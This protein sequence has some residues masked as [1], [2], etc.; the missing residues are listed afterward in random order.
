MSQQTYTKYQYDSLDRR[1]KMALA[2][3]YSLE[4]ERANNVPIIISTIGRKD[5]GTLNSILIRYN[6]RIL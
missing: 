2:K 5:D 6:K 3:Y 4:S 1:R